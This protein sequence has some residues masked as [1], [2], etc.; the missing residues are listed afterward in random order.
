MMFTSPFTLAILLINAQVTHTAI[1]STVIYY[2]R[3]MINRDTIL[4][5]RGRAAL[6]ALAKL[7]G[8]QQYF[9]N[10]H[11]PWRAREIMKLS[12]NPPAI[13]SYRTQTGLTH[14]E[15]HCNR[16]VILRWS[17]I[18]MMSPDES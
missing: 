5:I 2:A 6:P 16:T 4:V 10:W 11:R 7:G 13:Q 3:I 14:D 12:S 18:T 9:K 8:P 17:Y 1:S 15:P